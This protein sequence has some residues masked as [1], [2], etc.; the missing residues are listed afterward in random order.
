MLTISSLIQIDVSLQARHGRITEVDVES[1]YPGSQTGTLNNLNS[2][3]NHLLRD[4]LIHSV[5]NFQHLLGSPSSDMK[6]Q[7][8]ESSQQMPVRQVMQ[9]L[10]VM[11][12]KVHHES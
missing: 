4:V 8:Q 12:G 2:E 5:N 7:G 9:W 11:F 1:S 6:Q 10:N 3:L